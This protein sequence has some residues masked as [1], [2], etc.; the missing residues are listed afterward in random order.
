MRRKR[1]PGCAITALILFAFPLAAFAQNA[2]LDGTVR[3]PS[4]AVVGRVEV[5]LTN[6]AT[7]L[8]LVAFSSDTGHYQFLNVPRVGIGSENRLRPN[9][10]R[11]S[12]RAKATTRRHLTTTPKSVRYSV[13]WKQ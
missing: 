12:S 2:Q 5:V 10:I 9:S 7:N 8:S 11:A 1:L 4:R 6:K 13:R 3:D